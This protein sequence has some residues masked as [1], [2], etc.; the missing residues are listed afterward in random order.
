MNSG[1]IASIIIFI[2]FVTWSINLCVNFPT[3]AGTIGL[4]IVDMI[5]PVFVLVGLVLSIVMIQRNIM[6]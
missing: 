6:S 2:F 1:L 3:G 4:G 5:L